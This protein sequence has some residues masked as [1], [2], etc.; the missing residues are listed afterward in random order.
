MRRRF[1]PIRAIIWGE[2]SLS[3]VRST[4]GL[5]LAGEPYPK[6][7]ERPAKTKDG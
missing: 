5:G 1:S 2:K 3:G 4:A 7:E 6:G